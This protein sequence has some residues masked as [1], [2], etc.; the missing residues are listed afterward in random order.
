M[1]RLDYWISFD[2]ISV[3][4]L[5]S[6]PVTSRRRLA[7]ERMDHRAVLVKRRLSAAVGFHSISAAVGFHSTAAVQKLV[8][9]PVLQLD[10]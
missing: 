2:S 10:Q 1:F 5:L 6:Q 3:W 9:S 7:K 4:Q 8:G